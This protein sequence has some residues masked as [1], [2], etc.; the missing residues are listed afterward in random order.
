MTTTK[1]LWKNVTFQPASSVQ[2]G[3]IID[4]GSQQYRVT[5]VSHDERCTSIT[6]HACN[7]GEPY[8]FEPSHSLPVQN[9]P[10]AD[11]S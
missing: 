10:Q 6:F 5:K 3:D 2:V 11:K 9:K 4:Y 7:F 1:P 8:H